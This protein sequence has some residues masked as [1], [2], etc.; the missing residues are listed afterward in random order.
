MTVDLEALN[1]K[2]VRLMWALQALAMPANV[3]VTLYP[4]FVRKTDE[5]ALEFEEHFEGFLSTL[6]GELTGQRWGALKAVDDKLN[7]MSREGP[8]FSEALWEDDALESSQEWA[9]LRNLAGEALTELGW[10]IESPPQDPRDRGSIYV[11]G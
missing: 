1:F 7:A 5:L 9:T 8:K 4:D 6:A 11:G 3:Q 2:R 10:P